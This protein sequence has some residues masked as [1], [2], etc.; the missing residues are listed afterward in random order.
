MLLFIMNLNRGTWQKKTWME[1]KFVLL[2]SSR[3]PT[4]KKQ[5]DKKMCKIFT[6]QKK[7][8]NHKRRDVVECPKILFKMSMTKLLITIIRCCDYI[9][10]QEK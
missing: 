2:T 7:A 8:I 4:R 9:F 10:Y 1:A 3:F 5:N 6:L